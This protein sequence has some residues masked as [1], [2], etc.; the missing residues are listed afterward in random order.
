MVLSLGT[1]RARGVPLV[2]EQGA[3]QEVAELALLDDRELAQARRW[4]G[5]PV[6]QAHLA[7]RRPPR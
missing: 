1:S 7:G 6:E 2:V 4:L 3:A 5:Q